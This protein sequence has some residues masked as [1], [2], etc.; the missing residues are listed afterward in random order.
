MSRNRQK[1]A[2][3]FAG[4][5]PFEQGQPPDTFQQVDS[6]LYGDLADADAQR[7]IVRPVAIDRIVV[8]PEIQVRAGGLD[9]DTL[10]TYTQVLANDGELPPVVVFREGDPDTP[11]EWVLILSDGFHRLEAAR[12]A[13][14]S[15]V[16]A[17]IHAGGYDAAFLYAEEANLKHGLK[18][19]QRDKFN[20]FERR[21]LRGHEWCE[22]S[23]YAI[24]AI[25]GV[26]HT[27]ILRWR[28]R[29]AKKHPDNAFAQ[30][31]TQRQALDGKTYDTT[32][33]TEAQAL[34]LSPTQKQ[35]HKAVL[36]FRRLS[37]V[38]LDLGYKPDDVA[39]LERWIESLRSNFTLP[40]E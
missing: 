36:A 29:I 13:G 24:A 32:G 33:I 17:E 21:I 26:A 1:A 11:E 28:E 39:Q 19:N 10:D 4:Y 22:M 7:V 23:D 8:H 5:N 15:S 6:L 20:I 38:L 31:R 30:K 3:T 25:F 16:N 18:L 12:Q 9:P 2:S 34:K 40:E 37:T 35:A 14:K 27:T